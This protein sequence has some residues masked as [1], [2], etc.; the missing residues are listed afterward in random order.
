[1]ISDQIHQLLVKILFWFFGLIAKF[2]YAVLDLPVIFESQ[3]YG[4]VAMYRWDFNI[5]AAPVA[6]FK[7]GVIKTFQNP[8]FLVPFVFLLRNLLIL[9]V[10]ALSYSSRG[11]DIIKFGKFDIRKVKMLRR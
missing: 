1:M 4:D 6:E 3:V 10:V 8:L 11:P 2:P 5:L 9:T 7:A